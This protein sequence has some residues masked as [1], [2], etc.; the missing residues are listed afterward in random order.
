VRTASL[1]LLLH[2]LAAA[3]CGLWGAAAAAQALRLQVPITADL[4]VVEDPRTQAARLMRGGLAWPATTEPGTHLRLGPPTLQFEGG[5]ARQRQARVVADPQQPGRHVLEFEVVEPNVMLDAEVDPVRTA[6]APRPERKA[7]V[8]MNVYGNDGVAEVYQS[9]R[10]RL[11]DGFEALAALPQAFDWLTLSEWWNNA[12]WTGEPHAF[13]ITVDLANRGAGGRPGLFLHARA[14]TKPAG[15]ARWSETVWAAAAGDW[16]LPVRHWMTIETWYR[17]GDAAQ[18][19]FVLAVTPDG[20]Q[21]R[22]LLDV[23]DATRHPLT[24][25]VDGLRHFN[26]LKLYTSQAVVAAVRSTAPRLAVQWSDL[27]IRA[28][29]AS[30]T[31]P[32]PCEQAIGLR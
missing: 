24:G 8:Q 10:M 29:A 16:P 3:L 13:R 28:C 30:A 26:P 6:R 17:D 23:H 18:G 25:V 31:P 15:G 22:V 5:D 32:S 1:R 27:D 7:R 11:D 12:G 9:V 2:G 19:R 21:R 14:T 4:A 20:G